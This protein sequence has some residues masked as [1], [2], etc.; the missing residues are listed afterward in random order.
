MLYCLNNQFN[1]INYENNI[2]LIDN[3]YYNFVNILNQTYL[4][5]NYITIEEYNKF[6][7]IVNDLFN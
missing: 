1:Y 6:N 2:L 4:T 5:E 3:N 7:N